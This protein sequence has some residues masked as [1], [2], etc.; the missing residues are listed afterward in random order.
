MPMNN[1][2][3]KDR[4]TVTSEAAD[5]FLVMQDAR[6][7][8]RAKEA[9]LD[10]LHESPIH[11]REYLEVARLYSDLETIDPHRELTVR[12]APSANVVHLTASDAPAATGQVAHSQPWRRRFARYRLAAS[13]LLAVLFSAAYYHHVSVGEATRFTTAFGEQR[14][15]VLDDGSVISLNTQSEVDVNLNGD[16]RRVRLVRGEALFDVERDAG[17]PFV[18]ETSS[19][20]VTVT[21]TTFNVQSDAV[22]TAVTVLHGSVNVAPLDDEAGA[23]EAGAVSTNLA[24]GDQAVVSLGEVRIDRKM[25]RRPDAVAAWTQR[26]LVFDD[27]PLASVVEQFNRYNRKRL[28]IEDERLGALALSGVF[29]CN[30]LDS[31]ALFLKKID[32][33]DV[34]DA[35]DGSRIIRSREVVHPN[36]V[37]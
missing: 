33:V 28:V 34:V 9:L 22:S 36:A 23:G 17:R 14:S 5:W 21:G 31:L 15:V 35:P 11:V 4:S 30:D 2:S 10:W 27:E 16:V 12:D 32:G 19:A 18:V 20:V 25:L 37:P 29:S 7:S 26:K 13:V 3:A 8:Q 24:A 6:P 1:Q